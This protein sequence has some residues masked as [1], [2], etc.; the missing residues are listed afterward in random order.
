V[1]EVVVRNAPVPMEFVAVQDRFGQSGK[2]AVLMEEYGLT[3][4]AIV[5]A[6]KKVID[7]K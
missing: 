4:E 5:N 2:P 7:R 1:A 3:A 6:V